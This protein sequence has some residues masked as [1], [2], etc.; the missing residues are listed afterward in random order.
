MVVNKSDGCW[1]TL[2]LSE[3]LTYLGT[4]CKSFNH[5][6]HFLP[7]DCA[8]ALAAQM[9]LFPNESASLDSC[10]IHLINKQ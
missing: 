6:V 3:T 4:I 5:F 7:V 9:V 2:I 10:E 8:F 1:T